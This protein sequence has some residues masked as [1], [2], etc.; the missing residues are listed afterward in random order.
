MTDNERSNYLKVLMQKQSNTL[1]LRK[2][3]SILPNQ[4]YAI[5]DNILKNE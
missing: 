5:S 2:N 1:F 3:E 4:Y